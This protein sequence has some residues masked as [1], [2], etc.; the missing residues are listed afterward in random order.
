MHK[1]E[2][3]RFAVRMTI[4]GPRLL[5]STAEGSGVGDQHCGVFAFARLAYELQVSSRGH[6]WRSMLL[7]V[8]RAGTRLKIEVVTSCFLIDCLVSPGGPG[9]L[10]NI[11]SFNRPSLPTVSPE[12]SSPA[13]QR[14]HDAC[15]YPS[16][17]K[18][19]YL[20]I[21]PR[22]PWTSAPVM[23]KD[24]SIGL[25]S[26]LH[27]QER[28]PPYPRIPPPIRPISLVLAVCLTIPRISNTYFNFDEVY[29]WEARTY[30]CSAIAH[31]TL[32][33]R[34]RAPVILQ[35]PK[36]VAPKLLRAWLYM[37]SIHLKSQSLIALRVWPTK[38]HQLS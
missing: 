19:A 18:K 36:F 31:N 9:T 20:I 23:Q 26:G 3:P 34:S 25:E 17:L 32:G 30:C 22:L 15:G 7:L 16:R 29:I 21:P 1:T 10:R 27:L 33:F 5:S 28:I 38:A 35:L 24:S 2:E 8:L 4:C 13:E 11:S 14:G 12:S 6:M 37:A